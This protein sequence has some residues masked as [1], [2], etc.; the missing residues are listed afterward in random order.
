MDLLP[1][2]PEGKTRTDGWELHRGIFKLEIRRNF[3]SGRTSTQWNRLSSEVVCAPS[4]DIFKKR[5]DI[6]L[7]GIV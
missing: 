6:H 1:E 3:L 4:T 7:S 2:K 5:L